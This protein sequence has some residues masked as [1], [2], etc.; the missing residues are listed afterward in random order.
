VTQHHPHLPPEQ[1]IGP[2]LKALG[3]LFGAAAV[4]LA[5]LLGV[6]VREGTVISDMVVKLMAFVV[7]LLLLLV[8]LIVRPGWVDKLL[9]VVATFLP[10]WMTRYNDRANG[11]GR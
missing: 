7:G 4:I 3:L 10:N 8:A 5:V 6:T 2:F 1:N 11:G 9:R